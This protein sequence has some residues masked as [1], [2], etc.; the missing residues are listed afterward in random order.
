MLP[1]PRSPDGRTIRED[2]AIPA[3]LGGTKSIMPVTN[4]IE[5]S[6]ATVR[7]RT[8]KA[9]GCLSRATAL[10][11]VFKLAKS[12]ERTWRRLDGSDRLGQLIE[13]V[14]FRDGEPVHAT[15]APAAA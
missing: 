10:A 4:P 14:R 12:A 13:G 6:F 11:M 3:G 7:L 5:S 8:D 15:E 1:A 9:K 2:H